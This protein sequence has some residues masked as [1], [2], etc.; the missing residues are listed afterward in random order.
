MTGARV[1]NA[2]GRPAGDLNRPLWLALGGVLIASQGQG[3]GVSKWG[4]LGGLWKLSLVDDPLAL[5]AN[6]G[7]KVVQ[8]LGGREGHCPS[9]SEAKS[10]GV[11]QIAHA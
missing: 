5:L 2:L 10:L 3:R 7:E 1:G 6:V 9:R 11:Y 4:V 8:D